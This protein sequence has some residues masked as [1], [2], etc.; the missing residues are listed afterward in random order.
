MTSVPKHVAELVDV[1]D[2]YSCVR[3]GRSLRFTSGSRHH[4][5]RRAVGGHSVANLILLCGS[6]TTGCHGWAHA[7][8]RE[9]RAAGYIVRA[10]G[11]VTAGEVPVQ[12]V[13]AGPNSKHIWVMLSEQGRA[14]SV[15]DTLAKTLIGPN[16]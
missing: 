9:A 5:Q 3:C 1:R 10:D 11:L 12:V 2:A 16:L 4:R 7:H 6:G 8:P 15:P 14:V 13:S